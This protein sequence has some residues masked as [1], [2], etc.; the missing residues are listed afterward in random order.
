MA[1]REQILQIAELIHE[2]RPMHSFKHMEDSNEGI[3]AVMRY[4]SLSQAPVTAGMIAEFMGVSTARVAVLL[5]KM[6]AKGLI[7]KGTASYDARVTIVYLSEKGEQTVRSLD[8]EM[9]RKVGEIIDRIGMERIIQFLMTAQE[10]RD[11]FPGDRED[12]KKHFD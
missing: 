5:K 11:L 2:T 8:L 7:V 10:I 1:T 6:T 4:L 12:F 9:Q 3:G